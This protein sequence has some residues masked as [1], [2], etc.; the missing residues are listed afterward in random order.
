MARKRISV[1]KE[2]DNGRNQAFRDNYTG[3][4]MS[5]V[6]FV[7]AIK[8]GQYT[9]YHVRNINGVETPVSNPDQSTNNNLD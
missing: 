8:N 3:T 5:R 9:N 6:Q 1:K 7:K 2:D 4:D